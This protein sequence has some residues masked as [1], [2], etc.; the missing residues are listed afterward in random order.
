MTQIATFIFI[1]GILGLFFLNRDPEEK[2]SKALWIPV[3]WLLIIGS[4]P[5]SVWLQM[6]PPSSADQYLDGSP[7]DRNV[8]IG[9]LALGLIVLFNRRTAVAKLLRSNLWIVIFLLYCAV[10]VAWSDFPDVAFKRWIKFLGDHVMI[11]I[12]LT[13]SNQLG[14]IKRVLSRVTFVLLP[15]SVL[16]IKYYAV[17][18]RAYS[19][20]EGAAIYTGVTTNKNSLGL[21]CV[22]FGVGSFWRFLN[23]FRSKGAGRA[24]GPL[25]AH[26]AI[27]VMLMWLFWMANSVTSLSCFIMA[28]TLI[29][30][31]S[32]V[33]PDRNMWLVHFLVIAMLSVATASLFFGI[34]SGLVQGMGRDATLTGRTGIWRD[35]ISLT[36]NPVVGTGFESFW[37]GDRLEKIWNLY[38]WHPNEAH[39]G[40]IE[41]YLNLGWV[42]IIFVTGVIISGYRNVIRCLRGDTEGG[43]IRLAFFVVTLA[44][45]FTEAAI[46]TSS[47]VWM[48]FVLSVL[49]IPVAAASEVP[50][51]A[52]TNPVKGIGAR[53][54]RIAHTVPYGSRQRAT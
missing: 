53:K 52:T 40:Y 15:L 33:R 43:Q 17:L 9:L 7:L 8:Y 46:H 54:P 24:N 4:R 21:I 14:A 37:L 5:V 31:V 51:A 23:E 44:Y 29:V 16:F 30:A 36:V 10:S 6:A 3:V 50:V 19:R 32:V 26:G 18:G 42:G 45:N 11:L 12:V 2:T 48:M 47:V 41:V 13:D 25:I 27:L 1:V 39:N 35:V 28:S 49:A 22:I 38:W 20:W 34:G